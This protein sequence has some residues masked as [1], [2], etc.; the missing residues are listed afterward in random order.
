MTREVGNQSWSIGPNRPCS[1]APPAGSL[2]KHRMVI[3]HVFS[4]RYCLNR[5]KQYPR[6]PQI[7]GLDAQ[8]HDLA[9]RRIAQQVVGNLDCNFH[10]DLGGA[11]IPFGLVVVL[12]R[13]RAIRKA[14]YF[15]STVGSR[16]ADDAYPVRRFN[17][18]NRPLDFFVPDF[19]AFAAVEPP[20][21]D[22][23]NILNIDGRG[24]ISII[25]PRKHPFDLPPTGIERNQ[26]EGTGV[27]ASSSDDRRGSSLCPKS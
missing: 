6:C 7:V 26:S 22:A 11:F 3:Q 24:T 2:P 27:F 15:F 5:A 16:T 18:A 21:R 10:C 25:N 17:I 23:L 8:A 1:L 9:Y 20:H 12:L 14:T 13:S 19:L 4:D